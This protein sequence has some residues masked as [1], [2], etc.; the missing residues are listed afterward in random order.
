MQYF[1]DNIFPLKDMHSNSIFSGEIIPE[2]I[3][4]VE[5]F[6]QL[7]EQEHDVL[8]TDDGQTPRRSKK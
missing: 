4:H 8:E 1:F 7:N 5:T 6:E 3:T 2:P